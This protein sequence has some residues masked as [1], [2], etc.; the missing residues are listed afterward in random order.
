M[1]GGWYWRQTF[2]LDTGLTDRILPQRRHAPYPRKVMAG[3]T[4]MRSG[5]KRKE[6]E[7]L[8]FPPYPGEP[9][10]RIFANVSQAAWQQWVRLQPM[11]IDGNRLNLAGAEHRQYLALPIEKYFFGEGADPRRGCVPPRA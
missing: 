4:Q 3:V 6:A 10:K 2:A 11:I 5:A 8:D 1:E 9:G 7:E